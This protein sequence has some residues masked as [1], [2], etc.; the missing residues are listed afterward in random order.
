VQMSGKLSNWQHF[1]EEVPDVATSTV[2]V[3]RACVCVC[4]HYVCVCIMYVCG[5]IHVCM[6]ICVC[7]VSV[8]LCRHS[9]RL[10]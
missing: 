5:C 4:V 8:Y 2:R 6:Y 7:T 3:Y 10:V 9:N 1:G